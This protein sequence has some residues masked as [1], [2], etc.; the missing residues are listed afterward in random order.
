MAIG[1]IKP[2]WRN[3]LE[4]TDAIQ[5][6]IENDKVVLSDTVCGWW[7]DTG[8]KEDLLAANRVVLDEFTERKMR[9]DIDSNSLVEG[10]V[11]L[12]GNVV[13]INSTIHGPAT[14][15]KD[16]LIKNSK[17][18]P[19][20]SIGDATSISGS[21]IENS[22]ML[23]GCRISNINLKDSAIGM[24]VEITRRSDDKTTANLFVGSYSKVEL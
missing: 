9:G 2:S 8:K 23:S 4:I 7:L 12:S 16:C 13:L 20:T 21:I 5:W 1:K 6:L 10:R 19:F 24:N 15:G 22:I 14:V 17:I 18:G 3:E 11:D